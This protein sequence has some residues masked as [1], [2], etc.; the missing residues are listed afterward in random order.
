MVC[1][2][3]LVSAGTVSFTDPLDSYVYTVYVTEGNTTQYLGDYTTNETLILSS[4]E[5]YQ[6]FVKPNTVS[7]VSNPIEGARWTMAYIP[8]VFAC[9]MIGVIILGLFLVYRKGV[10]I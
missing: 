8:V 9:G 10:R 5:D 2:C 1:S 7:L 6:I 3:S 4:S